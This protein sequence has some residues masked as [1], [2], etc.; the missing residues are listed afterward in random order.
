[1][2]VGDFPCKL[3][4]GAT[5]TTILCTTSPTDSLKEYYNLPITVNVLGIGQATAT[6]KFSYVN[7]QT[8]I[9]YNIYPSVSYGG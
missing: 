1:M 6:E 9:L 8:P 3:Q 5:D 2:F 4:D 7:G